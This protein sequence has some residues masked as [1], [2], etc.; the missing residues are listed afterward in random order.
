MWRIWLVW[1]FLAGSLVA[2]PTIYLLAT[3]GTIAGSSK[4]AL[5]G[6]YKP[7]QLGVEALIEAIP[8][9]KNQVHL[10]G[11]QVSNIGSQEMDNAT[12]LKLA[13]RVS[14]LLK[15]SDVDGIVITHGTDTL[16]ESAYFLDLLIKSNKP[17]VLVGA[18]RNASSLSADGPLNLYNAIHVAM[19]PQA[20]GKGVLVVMD[21]AI[22]AAREASK[23]NTTRTDAFQSPNTGKIGMV[24]Y[25][26]V[27]FYMQSL[28]RH[29]LQSAFDIDKI[30]SLPRVDILYAHPNDHPD[31]VQDLIQHGS[32]GIIY[33]G[34]G[35]G[36]LYPSVLKALSL[37][38]QKGVVVVRSS[39]VPSGMIS[40]PGEVDDAKYGFLSGD[41]LNAPK[42]RVLLMLALSQTHDPK[43]IQEYFFTH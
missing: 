28:R 15:R 40:V 4:S 36:N 13:R 16:E 25:G 7:G 26:Q 5:S 1:V 18:M 38:V 9:L 29:T 3:G 8:Q 12:W 34:M 33:A 27:H 11:E 35:N 21:D 19:S 30:Q 39:R 14:A 23:M 43:K 2:K 6:A 10:K 20:R 31:L 22:H 32:K 41:D 17:I 37:A 24:L 42:A